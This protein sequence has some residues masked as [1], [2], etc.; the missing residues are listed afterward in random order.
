MTILAF[1]LDPAVI[2]ATLQFELPQAAS[3]ELTV[4]DVT[5]RLV[6]SHH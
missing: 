6:R 1:T 5:G 4:D 3:V 2:D